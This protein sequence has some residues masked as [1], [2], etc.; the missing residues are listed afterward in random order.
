MS[1]LVRQYFFVF[2][3]D[4]FAKIRC[5]LVLFGFSVLSYEN[6]ICICTAYVM[7]MELRN[8][9][10]N[11]KNTAEI[12]YDAKKFGNNTKTLTE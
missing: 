2:P 3:R 8:K 1:L 7:T 5:F 11:D 10:R 4:G 9:M 6:E 12:S